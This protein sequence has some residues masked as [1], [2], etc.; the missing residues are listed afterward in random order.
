MNKFCLHVS[1]TFDH[2]ASMN[3]THMV[4]YAISFFV[5]AQAGFYQLVK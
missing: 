1:G 3:N 2:I 4:K 5:S